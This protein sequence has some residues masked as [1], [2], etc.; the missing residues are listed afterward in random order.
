V[1]QE[2]LHIFLIVRQ[3]DGLGMNAYQVKTEKSPAFS[4]G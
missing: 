2:W 3:V 4:V 1:H